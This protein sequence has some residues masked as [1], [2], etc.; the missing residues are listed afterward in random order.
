MAAAELMG[1]ERVSLAAFVTVILLR[2]MV[3]PKGQI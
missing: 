3:P 2:V 1:S